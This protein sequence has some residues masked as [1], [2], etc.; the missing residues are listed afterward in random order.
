MIQMYNN[1]YINQNYIHEL[2]GMRDRI[3]RQLQ[4]ATQPQQQT[5]NINQTFQ[6]APP[7]QTGIKYANTIGDVNKELVFADTPFFSRDMSVMW[8]KNTKGEVKSYELKEIIERDEK[9]IM[10]ESLQLQIDE[11]KKGMIDNAK[12]VS[13][14]V[15]E[16]TQN[17]K[18]SSISN[19]KSS[20]K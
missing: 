11:L 13:D 7:T 9:D 6:I 8:L 1:P 2:Q 5:P 15:D 20:K 12:S 18:P 3:D 19:S 4:Q 17:K 14:D 16:P 10:I